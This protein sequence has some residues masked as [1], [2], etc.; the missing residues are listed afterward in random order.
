MAAALSFSSAVMRAASFGPTPWA[1]PTA[2]L[3][4][5]A[6]ALRTGGAI[7]TALDVKA[8]AASVPTTPQMNTA[9]AQQVATLDRNLT[10]R[11]DA[12]VAGLRNATAADSGL[13]VICPAGTFMQAACTATARTVWAEGPGAADDKQRKRVAGHAT[14]SESEPGLRRMVLLARSEP[15]LIL[16]PAQL[17]ADDALLNTPSGVVDLRTGA[18][19]PAKPSDYCSRMTAAPYVPGATH[20]VL[21]AFLERVLPDPA[22]RAWLDG[23]LTRWV[24]REFSQPSTNVI[25]A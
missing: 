6:T 14:H 5:N 7:A 13:C 2:A 9:I 19:R 20:P 25:A 24:A 18:L 17:D 22:V 1:R 4:S 16:R 15:G 8:D 23:F 21:A 10:A 12:A 11:L 3:S